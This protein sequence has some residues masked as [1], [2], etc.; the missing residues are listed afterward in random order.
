MLPNESKIKDFELAEDHE[1]HPEIFNDKLFHEDIDFII[2][3]SLDDNGV[4]LMQ[5]IQT[6]FCDVL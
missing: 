1:D 4:E 2:G 5:E 6:L 3:A